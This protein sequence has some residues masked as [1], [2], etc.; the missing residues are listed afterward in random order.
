M[1]DGGAAI[2]ATGQMVDGTR[3]D[4]ADSLRRAL[5]ERADQFAGVTV[6]KLLTYATGRA[7]RPEDMPSVRAVTR[8]AAPGRYRVSS[9]VLGVVGTPQ[10]QMRTKSPAARP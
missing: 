2:D 3:L 4:G 9:L 10:F 8:A 5:V 1:L 6:E 7:L